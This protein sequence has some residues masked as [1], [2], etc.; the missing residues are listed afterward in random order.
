M[1]ALLE[2]NLP[3]EDYDF[4]TAQDAMAYRRALRELDKHLRD[5]LKHGHNYRTIRKALED[6]RVMLWQLAPEGF[7]E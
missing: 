4:R 6:I 1:K 2:F 5:S 7:A 3:E